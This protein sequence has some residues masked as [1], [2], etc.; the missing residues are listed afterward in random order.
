MTFGCTG[1]VRNGGDWQYPSIAVAANKRLLNPKK[2]T[3]QK[4]IPKN[5]FIEL[6]PDEDFMDDI[7]VTVAAI[8]GEAFLFTNDKV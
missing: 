4:I 8:Y 7:V 6:L 2:A 1:V 3:K 5:L